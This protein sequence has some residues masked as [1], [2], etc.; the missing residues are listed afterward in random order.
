MPSEQ[1]IRPWVDLGLRW[2]D[3]FSSLMGRKAHARAWRAYERAK[4]KAQKT[5]SNPRP[6]AV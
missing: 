5:I 2:E 6:D 1:T 4:R 3:Y